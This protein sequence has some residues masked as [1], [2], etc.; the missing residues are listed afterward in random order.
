M[1]G[2]HV[3]VGKRT[4][5]AQEGQARELADGDWDGAAQL[6]DIEEPARMTSERRVR[7]LLHLVRPREGK[8]EEGGRAR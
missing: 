5:R 1:G 4:R 7:R 3:V 8:A 2:G 6:V